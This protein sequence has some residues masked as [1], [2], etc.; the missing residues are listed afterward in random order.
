[1]AD[2][3]DWRRLAR[4]GEEEERG[5]GKE[6]GRVEQTGKGTESLEETRGVEVRETGQHC[7]AWWRLGET[8]GDWRRLEEAR[9][10]L[11]VEATEA[12]PSRK[13]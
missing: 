11:R 13:K 6:R 1:M 12:T 10:N 9:A 7:R 4:T 3:G 5:R 2:R 8:R